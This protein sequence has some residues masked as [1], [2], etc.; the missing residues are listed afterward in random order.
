MR[1]KKKGGYKRKPH[2]KVF[3]DTFMGVKVQLISK[4]IYPSIV[5]KD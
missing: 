2:F 1:W 3:G 4:K 5:I